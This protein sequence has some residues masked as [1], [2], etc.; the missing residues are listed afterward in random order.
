SAASALTTT[1]YSSGTPMNGPT[2]SY[3]SDATATAGS[4][5]VAV[6]KA[7]RGAGRYAAAVYVNAITAAPSVCSPPTPMNGASVCADSTATA[8]QMQSR[9]M[10]TVAAPIRANPRL[11]GHDVG[12]NVW[13]LANHSTTSARYS[14]AASS[15]SASS[16]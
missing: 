16:G 8:S 14:A 6:A 4:H 13:G 15:E 7:A 12:C 11:S 3:R 5:S 10:A 2:S 9:R 1:K